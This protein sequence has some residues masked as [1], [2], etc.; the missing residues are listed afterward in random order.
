MQSLLTYCINTEREQKN[1]AFTNE[2]RT[3][4]Y[5]AQD[6]F[7]REVYRHE[8][9]VDIHDY[10]RRQISLIMSACINK[11]CSMAKN[12]AAACCVRQIHFQT[13]GSESESTHFSKEVIGGRSVIVPHCHL[14]R[15]LLQLD[16]KHKRRR[17][18]DYNVRPRE[19]GCDGKESSQ[20]TRYSVLI[21][22]SKSITGR[23]FVV[24]SKD[25]W[26]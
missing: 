24:Q 26:S 11:G 22:K 17:G 20:S 12:K 7:F 8:A 3:M 10:Q 15:L 19:N 2:L 9:K 6:F 21:N 16:A 23:S 18:G 13:W 1:Y 5:L 14:Q 4:L 25:M